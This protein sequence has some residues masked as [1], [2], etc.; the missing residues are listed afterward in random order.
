MPA[1]V[2][3]ASA[4][5]S[6]AGELP[7]TGAAA[8]QPELTERQQ[9]IVKA[10]NAYYGPALP[11]GSRHAT[12]CQQTSH[13]L[14]WLS[15]ND[16]RIAIAMARQLDWIRQWQPQ[17]REVEDL[18]ESA[19]VK[20]MLRRCPRALKELLEQAGIDTELPSGQGG[21]AEPQL[22]IDEWIEAIRGLF[23]TYPTLQEICEPHPTRLWPF[24]FFA[25]GA[26]YT[27][28]M[29]RC[30]YRLYDENPRRLNTNTLG[31]GDPASGKGALVRISDLICEPIVQADRLAV[32]ALNNWKDEQRSKGAN[33]DK[34]PRPKGCIRM[35]GARTSNQVFI[36]D[37]VNAWEEV[38]GQRWQ[39]HML[40]VDT[41]ALNSIKLQ[42]VGGWIDKQVMEIKAWSNEVDSQQYANL[43]AVSGFFKI[44]WNQVRT[45]TPP[46]LKL[47]ANDANFGTG[48]PTRLSVVPVPGSDF[49]MIE[50]RRQHEADQRA[51]EAIR[52]WA[53]R[54]DRRYGELPFDALVE[55]AWHWTADR[56]EIAKFNDDRADEL[57]LK[58]CAANAIAIAAPWIDM[59][60][61][62]E[63]EETGGYHTDGTDA[64][65]LD[66]VLDIQYRTQHYY[67]GALAQN[68]F[69]EQYEEATTFRRRTTRYQQCF[70][71]LPEEFTTEQ[72]CAIF[73]YANSHSANK[74]LNRLLNDKAISRTQR[75]MYK[76]RVHSI[77]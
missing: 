48:Y 10:L 3:P 21:Q 69:K 67:F 1:S 58:R 50:L 77:T 22:P 5:A 15:D 28:L 66:M 43:D 73:G 36:N 8:A 54:L 39:L 16:S 63:R 23:G 6:P 14:L 46:A 35:H 25:A 52:G 38:D 33:K 19:A 17:P 68:Y 61:T 53:Y 40:T 41:E 9:A 24:L 71:A 29:T 47:L 13:W 18:I 26:L 44:Y 34:A 75:G 51:D 64:Q 31:V 72:F 11:E 55:H 2:S 57:L 76:K 70:L 56:M 59:R 20:K 65:L 12:L 30:F 74:T 4:S 42:K 49:Q 37:M 45:C 7:D 60:H 32:E 62:G 27:T